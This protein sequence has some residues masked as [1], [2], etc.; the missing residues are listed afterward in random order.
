MVF[1]RHRFTI[2][3]LLWAAAAGACSARRPVPAATLVAFPG[4]PTA[5]CL[6]EEILPKIT[7]VRPTQITP[8]TEMT[9]IATGGYLRDTCGGYNESAQLYKI[10][11]DDKPIADLS[12]YVNHCESR[13][14]LPDSTTV[15]PHC[16]G[17]LKGTCQLRFEVARE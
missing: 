4:T 10:Y 14:A 17:V 11:V 6:Q 8:G 1:L 15:G 7:E 13:F 5:E 9:V 2:A 16:M 3:L 12:C